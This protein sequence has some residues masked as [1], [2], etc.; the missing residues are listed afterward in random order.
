MSKQKLVGYDA[1]KEV[2]SAPKHAG[3]YVGRFLEKNGINPSQASKQLGV[4]QSTVK[5]LIDG[6]MLTPSMAAKLHSVF[7]LSIDLLFKLDA[8][9]LAHTAIEQLKELESKA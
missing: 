7:G 4:H 2:L 8:K 5:R 1:L 3:Y 6:A 9:Y